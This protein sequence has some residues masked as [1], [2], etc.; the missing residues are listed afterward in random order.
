MEGQV[1]ATG[2]LD[3]NG[4]GNDDLPPPSLSQDS[5]STVID[6]DDDPFFGPGFKTKPQ[7]LIEETDKKDKTNLSG[8]QF[9]KGDQNSKKSKKKLTCILLL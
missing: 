1:V 7:L 9:L 8:I 5:F 6:F 2:V 4:F 3:Y